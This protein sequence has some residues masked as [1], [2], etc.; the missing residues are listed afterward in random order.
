[1]FRH[2]DPVAASPALL[3]ID[4]FDCLCLASAAVLPTYCSEQ[5]E[6][7][8]WLAPLAKEK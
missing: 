8:L 5:L 6:H 1:M 2:Q 4:F 7:M 3:D